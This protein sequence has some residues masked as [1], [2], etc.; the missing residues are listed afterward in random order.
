MLSTA[1]HGDGNDGLS[2]FFAQSFGD[3][4]FNFVRRKTAR[5]EIAHQGQ[6]DLAILMHHDRTG[7]FILVPDLDHQ[8]VGRADLVGI[9]IDGGTD[10]IFQLAIRIGF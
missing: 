9:G 5:I 8:D 1:L 7:E 3:R 6:G 10:G 2:Q 4:G